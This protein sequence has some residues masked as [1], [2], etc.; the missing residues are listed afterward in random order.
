MVHVKAGEELATPCS[1]VNVLPCAIG[2]CGFKGWLNTSGG[3]GGSGSYCFGDPAIRI[4][5]LIR[6][7]LLPVY[8]LHSGFCCGGIRNG[9][10]RKCRIGGWRIVS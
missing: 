7:G 1:R 10:D 3:V 4:D 6:H 9:H 5:R 8:I 2:M